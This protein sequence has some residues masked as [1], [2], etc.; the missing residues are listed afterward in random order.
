MNFLGVKFRSLWPYHWISIEFYWNLIDEITCGTDSVQFQ[1]IPTEFHLVDSLLEIINNQMICCLFAVWFYF[2]Y[3]PSASSLSRINKRWAVDSV[4]RHWSA[5]CIRG[6]HCSSTF[7]QIVWHQLEAYFIHYKAIGCGFD[8]RLIWPRIKPCF[9]CRGPAF[10]FIY[11]SDGIMLI[12]PAGLDFSHCQPEYF[13]K[14]KAGSKWLRNNS[15]FFNLDIYL[16]A[17]KLIFIVFWLCKSAKFFIVI[18][19]SFY[20]F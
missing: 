1:W 18:F 19:L 16:V 8:C 5:V 10:W 4:A 7:C 3:K 9:W 17:G 20:E 11:Y 2:V 15:D 13:R 14:I 12:S 6:A